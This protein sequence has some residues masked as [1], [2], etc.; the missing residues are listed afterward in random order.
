LPQ[1]VNVRGDDGSQNLDCR[2]G[3]FGSTRC[4]GGTVAAAP[5]PPGPFVLV[6]DATAGERPKATGDSPT[7]RWQVV[8]FDSVTIPDVF[9]PG[10]RD[11]RPT[12]NRDSR[13][14]TPSKVS[15]QPFK[16]VLLSFEGTEASAF[17]PAGLPTKDGRP[18]VWWSGQR[19]DPKGNT[20]GVATMA[21]VPRVNG[22]YDASGNVW[23]GNE[24]YHLQP[25][26]PGQGV[27][28]ELDPD[29]S[30]TAEGEPAKPVSPQ[31]QT[32][33]SANSSIVTLSTGTQPALSKG[34]SAAA[35]AGVAGAKPTIDVIVGYTSDTSSGVLSFINDQLATMNRA[36]TDSGIPERVRLVGLVPAPQTMNPTDLAGIQNG[37]DH[38]KDPSDGFFDDVAAWRNTNRA[39]LALLVYGTTSSSGC[40]GLANIPN[41][42]PSFDPNVAFAVACEGNPLDGTMLSH[43]FGHLLGGQHDIDNG[44]ASVPYTYSHGYRVNGLART[45]MAYPCSLPCPVKAQYSNPNVNFI[46]VVIAAGPYL[47]LVP[48]GTAAA[49]N[50]T[51]FSQ[52]AST[53]ARYRNPTTEVGVFRPSNRRWYT[54]VYPGTSVGPYGAATDLPAVGDYNGDWL[55]DVGVFRPSTGMWYS[56]GL[57]GGQ[58]G[59]YGAAGDLPAVGDFN[60]DGVSDIGVYRPSTGMWYSPGLPGGQAGPFGAAGDVPAIGDYNSD[61][62]S[63]IGVYRATTQQWFRIG[64]ATTTFG[65]AG[66]RPAPGDYNGDGKADL[67]YWVPSTG[68][69]ILEG[70]GVI[71]TWGLPGDIPTPGEYDGL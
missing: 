27:W 37:L 50:A 49:N 69:W 71:G 70:I 1:G 17:L 65:I 2:W 46:G 41:A 47:N 66:A 18:I 68:Q 38:L 32:T 62:V 11:A 19:L 20:L 56:P 34:L 26:G 6:G 58:A 55:S 39:D 40:R 12:S 29:N 28:L 36:L 16:D 53:V 3:G 4:R 5:L 23:D 44:P 57:S 14:I 51:S 9:A 54:P 43:E 60:G 21:F 33:T 30:E 61:G 67:A 8:T 24:Q 22:G 52:L 42:P 45:I 31:A 64:L 48:S 59:P 35:A 10:A 15:W 13:A 63:D 7:R 25:T